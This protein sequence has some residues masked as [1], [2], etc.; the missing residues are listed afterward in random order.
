VF[1]PLVLI[2]V[3]VLIINLLQEKKSEILPN[4]LKNW[5]F[6]P[7]PLRSLEPYDKIIFKYL[8]CCKCCK[9]LKHSDR[10]KIEQNMQKDDSN[11]SNVYTNDAFLVSSL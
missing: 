9:K 1:C 6:L 7:E 4:I 11:Y 8:F 3:S 2:I 5:K 10:N